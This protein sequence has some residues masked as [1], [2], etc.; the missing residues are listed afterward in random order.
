MI[1]YNRVLAN[2]TGPQLLKKLPAFCETPEL[3]YSIYKS[4]PAD[5]TFSQ[6]NLVHSPVP[7]L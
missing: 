5:P 7:H 4:P 2:L 3:H 1:T 6:I